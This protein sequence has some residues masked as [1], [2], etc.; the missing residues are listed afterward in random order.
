MAN[1]LM[2]YMYETEQGRQWHARVLAEDDSDTESTQ[3][4]PSDNQDNIQQRQSATG[5]AITQDN[6]QNN[7]MEQAGRSLGDQEPTAR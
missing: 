1:F 2:E 6:P 4:T 5:Q 3:P 7:P